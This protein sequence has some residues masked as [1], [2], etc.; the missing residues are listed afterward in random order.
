MLLCLLRDPSGATCDY[1]PNPGPWRPWLDMEHSTCYNETNHW[2]A[3]TDG[4]MKYVFRAWAPDLATQEQLFNLT[5]DPGERVQL[6]Q[7]A[8]VRQSSPQLPGMLYLSRIALRVAM[9][10]SSRTPRPPESRSARRLGWAGLQRHPAVARG[11]A[12]S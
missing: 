1:A 6:S 5:T 4:R 10:T 11:K 3:L 12:T 9:W 7:H 2:S 8:A